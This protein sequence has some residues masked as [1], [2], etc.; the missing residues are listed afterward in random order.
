MNFTVRKVFTQLSATLDQSLYGILTQSDGSHL[1]GYSEG[2][3]PQVAH[4]YRSTDQGET[5]QPR[6]DS[7][8]DIAFA[9]TKPANCPTDIAVYGRNNENGISAKIYRSADNANSWLLTGDWPFGTAMGSRVNNINAIISYNRGDFLAAGQFMTDPTQPPHYLARS[10]DKGLTWSTQAAWSYLSTHDFAGTLFAAGGGRMYCGVQHRPVLNFKASMYRS[11]DNGFSWTACAALPM[12]PTT[13][14]SF[15]QTITAFTRDHVLVGGLAGTDPVSNTAGLWR[16]T[17]AGASW[18]RI[19]KSAI[20]GW[21]TGGGYNTVCE[22]KRLTRWIG[23]MGWDQYS[24]SPA[25][26]FAA[27]NDGGN[28]FS[29]PATILTG[30]WPKNGQGGGSIVQTR[31]GNILMPVWATEDNVSSEYQVWLGRI[32]P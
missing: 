18:T 23:I 26:L 25:P 6:A 2:Y 4:W 29:I 28:T 32:E 12:P 24:D 16:S 8:G 11:D 5:W 15:T 7:E 1:F 14:G 20:S 19:D 22:L 9:Y 30:S 21:P 3:L 13:L 17:D 10:L 27:T 31:N